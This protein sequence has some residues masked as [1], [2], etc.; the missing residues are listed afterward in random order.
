MRFTG[1]ASQVK[2]CPLD[3]GAF[4]VWRL[5]FGVWR[6]AFGVWRRSSAAV[7]RSFDTV[8][9]NLYSRSS[10]GSMLGLRWGSGGH[11][12]RTKTRGQPNQEWSVRIRNQTFFRPLLDPR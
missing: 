7:G 9:S 3:E 12:K 1:P 2:K 5:A 11:G 10:P 4:G 6:L 8:A